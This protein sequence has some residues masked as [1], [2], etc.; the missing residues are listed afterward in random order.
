MRSLMSHS[1]MAVIYSDLFVKGTSS[2]GLKLFAG[3]MVVLE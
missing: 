2:V 3:M 1:P